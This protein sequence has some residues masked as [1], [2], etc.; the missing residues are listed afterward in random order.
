MC[1]SFFSCYKKSDLKKGCLSVKYFNLVH[2]SWYGSLCWKSQV[3]KSCKQK[4]TSHHSQEAERDKRA[5]TFQYY[6]S[7]SVQDFHNGTVLLPTLVNLH[8]TISHRSDQ[9]PWSQVALELMMSSVEIVHHIKHWTH[10]LNSH[11]QA[12][13]LKRLLE[14]S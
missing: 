1:L 12:S 11:P 9:R 3:S 2:S 5:Y 13:S 7:V 14:F 8:K 4:I 6:F 10:F